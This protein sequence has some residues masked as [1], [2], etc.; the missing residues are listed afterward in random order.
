LDLEYKKT[1]WF[2]DILSIKLQGA[3]RIAEQISLSDI[4]S[5]PNKLNAA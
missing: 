1:I 2:L 4:N 5:S 3:I